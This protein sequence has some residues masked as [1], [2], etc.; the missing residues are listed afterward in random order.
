MGTLKEIGHQE[1]FRI[2]TNEI[3]LNKQLKITSLLQ[4]MQ[5]ASMANAMQLNVSVW[6]LEEMSQSWVLVKKEIRIKALPKLGEKIDVITYPSGLERMFAYRDFIVKAENGDILAVA[7]SVWILMDINSRKI[8]KP[9]FTIPTPSDVDILERPKF[10]LK[11]KF[12]D[13][14]EKEFTINWFDLDWNKHVNNVF[15]LKCFLETAPQS[16]LE[17]QSIEKISIQFKSEGMLS[18]QL[19]SYCHEIGDNKTSHS[20]IRKE[21]EKLIALAQIEWK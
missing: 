17:S 4:L 3:D 2:R 21:D 1:S 16:K 5:E 19:I 18:E 10:N 15:L 12:A 20:I 7:S 9:E 14:I 11:K 13:G 6:D 8:V